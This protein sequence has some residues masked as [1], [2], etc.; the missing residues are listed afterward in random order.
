[1]TYSVVLSFSIVLKFSGTRKGILRVSDQPD[2]SRQL[3]SN[4]ML[5]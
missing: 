5:K 1:M 3:I 4:F 2:P